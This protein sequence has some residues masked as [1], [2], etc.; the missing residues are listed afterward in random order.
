MTRSKVKLPCEPNRGK[1]DLS[2]QCHVELVSRPLSQVNEL[3][4][5]RAEQNLYDA[6]PPLNLIKVK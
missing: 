2:V 5:T 4:K 3:F 6:P 1:S